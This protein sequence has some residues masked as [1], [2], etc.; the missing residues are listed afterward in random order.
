MTNGDS[1]RLGKAAGLSRRLLALLVGLLAMVALIAS[2]APSAAAQ[3]RVGAQPQ[4]LILTV[5]PQAAA[6]PEVIGLHTVPQL[7][8]ASATGVAAETADVVVPKAWNAAT[9]LPSG[10]TVRDVGS[11]IW[12]NGLPSATRLSGMTDAELRG[13][14]SLDDAKMLNAMYRGAQASVPNNAT[15]PIRVQLSQQVID[16]W[17]RK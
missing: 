5:G 8:L 4:N 6:A 11:Q 17:G 13:L 9:K 10:G 2:G 3:T 15:A 12:G 16:A 1:E 7:R 14:A